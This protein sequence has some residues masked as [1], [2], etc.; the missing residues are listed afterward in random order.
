MAD[1][2]LSAPLTLIGCGNMAGAMLRRWLDC[3]LEPGRV[4]AVRPSGAPVA[5]GVHVLTAVP[6][7]LDGIV[8]IG[9]KPQKLDEV[10]PALAAAI[11]PDTLLLSILA[12]VEQA[13]LR[14][15]FPLVEEV[16]RVMPNTPVAIG[17][18]AVG[19]FADRLGGTA[20][21]IVD[22]LMAPLGTA[23]WVEDEALFDVV[24]ALAASGPA[25]VF[26][27]I[28]ALAAGAAEL[29]LP[30]EQAARL[31]L[32]TVDGAGALAA[33]A[34]ESPHELAERVASP[35]GMTREG[36]NVLDGEDA[37]RSLVL[38]TLDAAVRRSREM[39]EAARAS[40]QDF[41]RS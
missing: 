2:H 22:R 36:L 37:L 3:G 7:A 14:A 16:V 35:G 24:A 18:G 29:G 17:K 25:F 10:A 28:D 27:F 1:L 11:G 23:E 39:G 6:E 31:A 20:R 32:A 9:V 4:K 41:P 33:A 15:R 34:G 21:E 8:L 40:K 38:R 19:L 12:G 13:S 5:E 30:R 26:R